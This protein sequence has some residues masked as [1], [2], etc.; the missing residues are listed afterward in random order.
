MVFDHRT[1]AALVVIDDVRIP[2]IHV[3][4]AAEGPIC[5]RLCHG[6]RYCPAGLG[7]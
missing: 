4:R 1:V 3:G 7:G 6:G 5:R 2:M